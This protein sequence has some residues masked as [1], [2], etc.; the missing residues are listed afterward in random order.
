MSE[1][2]LI[3]YLITLKS[4]IKKITCLTLLFHIKNSESAAFC[5]LCCGVNAPQKWLNC[6]IVHFLFISSPTDAPDKVKLSV[7]SSG[8]IV[9]GGTVTFACSSDAN[10]PVTQ[11]GYGLYKDG[12]LVSSGQ[13]HN[14]SDIQPG[15]SGRYYCQAWNNVSRMGIDLVNSTEVVLDVKCE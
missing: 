2:Y 10:P 5:F 3:T 9:Q 8:V 11:S 14:I 4:L 13:S 6:R 12:E 1:S 15:H 7:G